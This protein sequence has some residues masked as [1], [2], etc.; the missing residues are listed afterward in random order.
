MDDGAIVRC[1]IHPGIGTARVGNSPDAYFVGP[2]VPGL[3][4]DP[5]DGFKDAQGRIKRQA[6]RFRI[7]PCPRNAYDHG[8][9]QP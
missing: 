5:P 9:T 3:V 2:E 7:A 1:M 4:P 8:R 6:A